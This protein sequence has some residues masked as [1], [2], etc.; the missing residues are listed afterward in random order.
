MKSDPLKNLKLL[1]KNSELTEFV[2]IVVLAN[3]TV[4]VIR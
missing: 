3:E 2:S 4:G 1:M